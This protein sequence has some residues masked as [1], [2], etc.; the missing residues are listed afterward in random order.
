MFRIVT[1]YMC[2]K[3][4]LQRIGPTTKEVLDKIRKDM[5]EEM[6]NMIQMM[7]TQLLIMK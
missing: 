1:R 7:L 3:S 6:D 4:N 2:S 5:Q